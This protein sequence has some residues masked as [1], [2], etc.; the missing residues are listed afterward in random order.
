MKVSVINPLRAGLGHYSRALMH[1]LAAAGVTGLL[2][3]VAEPSASGSSRPTWIRDYLRAAAG[4]CTTLPNADRVVVTWPTLGFLDFTLLQVVARHPVR[5]IVMHDPTPLVHARGY[6]WAARHI[7]ESR[8]VDARAIVH[9]DEALKSLT[10]QSTIA[11]LLLPHPMFPPADNSRRS[12]RA[13][14]RVIGQYKPDRDVSALRALRECGPNEWTYEI[15][16]RGWPAVPGWRI[17]AGF[18]PEP[19]FVEAIRSAS[20]VL[21]PYRRFFQSGVA[22]RC[23]ELGVPFVGPRESSLAS[24]VGVRSPWLVSTGDDWLPAVDAALSASSSTVYEV[25]GLAYA[26]ALTAWAR[27]AHDLTV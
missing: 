1:T 13:V 5:W 18:L 17:R 10:T 12:S 21:I 23:L 25:G 4:A 19:E 2:V 27:W 26:G 3:E 11:T 22:F 24:I 15:V 7:A 9:S 16:G 20:V 6:G 14:V 8:W